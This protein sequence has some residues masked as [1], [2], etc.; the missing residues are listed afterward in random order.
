M[1]QNAHSEVVV[2]ELI[3]WGFDENEYRPSLDAQ[4]QT[5]AFA[6]SKI[7]ARERFAT[8]DPTVTEVPASVTDLMAE[9][10]LRTDLHAEMQDLDWETGIVDIR[11]LLAFQRRLI[12]DPKHPNSAAPLPNDWPALAALAFGPPV[13]VA[14]T[15][16]AINS[17]EI[18][19]QSTNPTFSYARQQWV[20]LPLSHSTVEAPFLR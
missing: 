15:T 6:R 11:H 19:L 7:N 1:E 8:V 2:R 9:Q 17:Q 10:L 5:I 14:Y 13:S 20:R 16:H 3:G 18:W 4:S 12:S